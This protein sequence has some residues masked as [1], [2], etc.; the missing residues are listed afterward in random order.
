MLGTQSAMLARKGRLMSYDGYRVRVAGNPQ[1]Y[2]VIDNQKCHV[3]NPGT[4]NNLFENWNDIQSVTQN[5]KNAIPTGTA[6]TS[7]AVLAKGTFASVYLITNG[8]KRHEK[9]PETMD[10]Y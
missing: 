3:P 2:V 9:S 5:E 10:K 4:Y 6:L 1:V 8:L 7:G